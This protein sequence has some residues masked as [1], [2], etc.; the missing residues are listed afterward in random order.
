MRFP[1]TIVDRPPV[2]EFADIQTGHRRAPLSDRPDVPEP[3][4]VM[5][6]V[7][8]LR[9]Q[10]IPVGMGEPQRRHR[11]HPRQINRTV[12]RL[13]RNAVPLDAVD[14]RLAQIALRPE[15][16]ALDLAERRDQTAA[17]SLRCL[18]VSILPLW[19]FHRTGLLRQ[20]R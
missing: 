8:V 13:R 6:D 2:G 1:T 7:R 12:E 4:P 19:V 5:H 11:T 16:R 3:V 10:H 14:P 15:Q 20:F 9:E 17:P 18:I